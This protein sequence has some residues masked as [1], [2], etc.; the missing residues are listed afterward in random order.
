[1]HDTPHLFLCP[2]IETLLNPKDLW[3]IPTK[4][5]SLLEKWQTELALAEE[6]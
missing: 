5:A 1:M 3:I 2:W 6:I 4:V